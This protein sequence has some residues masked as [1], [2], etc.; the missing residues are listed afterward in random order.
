MDSTTERHRWD[1]FWY[2]VIG[3]LVLLGIAGFVIWVPPSKVP[4]RK[5]TEFSFYS[6]M[7]FAL[8][9]KIYWRYRSR[10][11]MWLLLLASLAL[12]LSVYLPALRQVDYSPT[13]WYV[14]TMPVEAVLVMLFMWWLLHL[15]PD[16]KVQL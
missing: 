1:F 15:G 6:I 10:L 13:L 12:H 7:L 11:K 16:H 14:A 3:L 2:V 8:L 5:W 9:A 4:K